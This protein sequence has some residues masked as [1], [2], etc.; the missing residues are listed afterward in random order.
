MRGWL[1]T[2]YRWATIPIALVLFT[3]LCAKTC[4][5]LQQ[6]TVPHDKDVC[7]IVFGGNGGISRHYRSHTQP[8]GNIMYDQGLTINDIESG[9]HVL[10]GAI[11][12][13]IG[14]C[15][16]PKPSLGEMLT[17]PKTP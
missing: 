2:N 11:G 7:I 16:E 9:K 1:G 13:D 10:R 3:L 14:D 17:S 5:P 4:T 15:Y 6:T 12:T 8:V